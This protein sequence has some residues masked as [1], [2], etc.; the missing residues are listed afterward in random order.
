MRI[1]LAFVPGLALAGALVVTTMLL[2]S[3]G[4]SQSGADLEGVPVGAL[5]AGGL[6]LLEPTGEAA[7]NEVVAEEVARR[8]VQPRGSRAEVRQTALVHVMKEGTQPPIDHL[9]WAI[10]FDPLTVTAAMPYGGFRFEL[11]P[12]EVGCPVPLYHVSFV[13]AKT[14]EFLF[15][16][17]RSTG[18]ENCPVDI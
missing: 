8:N 12:D 5:S 2:T 15:S 10:N 4:G 11:D 18:M 14:G 16:M 7:V 9:A 1:V 17:E 3:G 13:D 6:T